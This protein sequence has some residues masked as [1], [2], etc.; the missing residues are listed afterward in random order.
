MLRAIELSRTPPTQRTVMVFD[1]Q[2]F[3]TSQSCMGSEAWGSVVF[4]GDGLISIDTE[5]LL[6]SVGV[7]S[8][9]SVRDNLS[10]LDRIR[11]YLKGPAAG[12]MLSF[13]PI[14][15]HKGWVKGTM[16]LHYSHLRTFPSNWWS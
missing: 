5:R 14:T 3:D 1:T 16:M 4:T 6:S 2:P 10:E 7:V 9:P 8:V 15:S 13:F 11:H 12:G